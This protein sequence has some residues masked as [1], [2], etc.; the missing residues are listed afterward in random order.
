LNIALLL[1]LAADTFGDRVALRSHDGD[2]TFEQL[3]DAARTIGTQLREAGATTLAYADA[4]SCAVPAALFGA[5]WA[6]AAYAPLNF[7]LPAESLR[8]QIERLGTP[9]VVASERLCGDLGET[10]GAQEANAWF[11]AVRSADPV[12]DGD[13][14]PE[15][16]Q[17]AVILFTSGT[18]GT[19]K[20]AILTHDNLLAYVMETIEF[21][22]ADDDEANLLAAPPFH[23]A[24]VASV[25]TSLYSGRSIIPLASFSAESW[26]DHARS[27]A[28][29]HAF[30][31]PTMLA[32]IVQVMDADP[33]LRVPSLR[34]LS[35]G[36]ARMGAPILERAL[37]LF[38]DVAFVN[39]YGLTETSSTISVLGPDDHRAAFTSDDPLVRRRLE[40]AGRPVPGIEVEIVDD[41][42]EPVAQGTSGLIRLRGAQVS[43]HYLDTPS[44][45][46]ESGWLLTGDVGFLDDDGYLFVEGRADDV[47]IKGGENL[48]PSEIEDAL[49]R[50]P[51]VIAVT[52]VGIPDPDWG[53]SV[54]AA[55]V[56]DDAAGE[57]I[58]HDVRDEL[59]DWVRG[60]LGSLKT[61]SR[62]DVLDELPTTAT[63]KVL[64][65]EIRDRMAGDVSSGAR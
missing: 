6:G 65:R 15:P 17:P 11:A 2:V 43:G 40:S 47:I 30:L 8:A 57:R 25:M 9:F 54:G 41:Q 48:S 14:E 19:P 51:L 45:V 24:G 7:R 20:A 49:L 31:V 33:S 59:T 18:S 22:S 60:R 61:P 23:I 35:Y 53:E 12:A 32:R 27:H 55:V 34:A 4:S 42:G 29:T 10:V 38:D 16:D 46:S 21:A 58:E 63:G 64:R 39:A 1:D 36:G 52:V 62:I 3:R 37:E 5:A 28:A 50:H 44:S 13:Y 56:I 26:L